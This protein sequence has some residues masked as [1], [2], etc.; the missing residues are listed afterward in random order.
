MSGNKNR[1]KISK[2]IIK[3]EKNFKKSFS[4]LAKFVNFWKVFKKK[5]II[6]LVDKYGALNA[7]AFPGRA[8]ILIT[9]LGLNKK[10][11]KTIYEQ[12]TS[13]KIGYFA[14]GTQIPIKSDTELFKKINKIKVLVNFAW[15]ISKEIRM[16]LKQKNF[17]GK[18]INIL[19]GNRFNAR[20]TKK[21]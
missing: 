2:K 7:K 19:D 10:I 6:K 13:K 11:I 18:L 15:H 1:V 14:P 17:D 3:K 20:N 9:L 16:Y 4:K 8:A 21:N 5:E 12:P